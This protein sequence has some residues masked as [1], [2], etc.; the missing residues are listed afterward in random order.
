M[1]RLRIERF[2][3]AGERAEKAAATVQ[4]VGQ[5]PMQF[6]GIVQR[7]NGLRQL[8]SRGE[9]RARDRKHGDAQQQVDVAEHAAAVEPA[10]RSALIEAILASLP[11]T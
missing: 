5:S 1:K 2:E 11:D 3:P 8:H 10:L 6:A 9:L 7:A 4:G